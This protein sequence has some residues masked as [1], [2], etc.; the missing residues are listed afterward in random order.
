MQELLKRN[1]GLR[2]K[3][4]IVDD[5]PIEREMLGYML[6]DKYEIGFAENGRIALEM[7]KKEKMILS[8]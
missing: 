4:L 1:K 3:I 7:I 6:N 5:E 2:R 8:F